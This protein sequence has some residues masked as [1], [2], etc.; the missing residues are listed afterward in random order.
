MERLRGWRIPRFLGEWL[1]LL[2]WGDT[3]VGRVLRIV[4]ATAIGL[5]SVGWQTQGWFYIELT[6]GINFR[7]AP[8]SGVLLLM[9]ALLVYVLIT[10]GAAWVRSSGP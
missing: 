2:L 8:S 1:K 4:S 5:G 7:A 9:S 3:Q 10:A 6:P